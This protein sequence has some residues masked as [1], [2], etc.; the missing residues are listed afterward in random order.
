M[1]EQCFDV[2]APVY[3]MK[4]QHVLIFNAIDDDIFARGETSQ[5]GT[6]ILIAASSDVWV[7]GK[8]EK[9]L[10]D[11]IDHAVGNLGLPLSFAR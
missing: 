6:Q 7:M 11:G 2:T 8:K 10:G 1:R 9:P 4:N 5:A 3:H